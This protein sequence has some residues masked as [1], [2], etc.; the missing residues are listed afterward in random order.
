M[1]PNKKIV[2]NSRYFVCALVHIIL[3]LKKKKSSLL[4]FP[5]Y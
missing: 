5:V 1:I 4:S 3:F 2:H